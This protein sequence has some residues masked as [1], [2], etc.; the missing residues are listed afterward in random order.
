[1]VNGQPVICG[2]Q[3]PDRELELLLLPRE[4]KWKLVSYLT[5]VL[6]HSEIITLQDNIIRYFHSYMNEKRAYA[7]ATKVP[8]RGFWVT[9][10]RTQG[11]Y[12]VTYTTELYDNSG[13]HSVLNI[14]L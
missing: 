5:Q 7:A 13:T 6:G 8:T 9:G 1:M 14:T 2:G 12:T 10:G 11:D 3:E 4:R